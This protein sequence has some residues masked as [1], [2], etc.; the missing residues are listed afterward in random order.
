M[1]NQ[2]VAADGVKYVA[3]LAG[4]AALFDPK[5]CYCCVCRVS[6]CLYLADKVEGK[7]GHSKSLGKDNVA[8]IRDKGKEEYP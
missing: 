4:L 8:T 6:H 5:Q 7:I 2:A 1:P 3:E